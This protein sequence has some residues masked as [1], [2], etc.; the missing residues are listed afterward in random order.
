VIEQIL[1][2][3][4][5]LAEGCFAQNVPQNRMIRKI[6]RNLID[7]GMAMFDKHLSNS[8]RVFRWSSV[9]DFLKCKHTYSPLNGTSTIWLGA[10]FD[11]VVNDGKSWTASKMAN[12]SG[13]CYMSKHPSELNNA[14]TR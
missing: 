9:P 3:A 4:D 7:I 13:D 12:S 5:V 10:M 1:H 2:K 8:V 11:E 6:D 14:L